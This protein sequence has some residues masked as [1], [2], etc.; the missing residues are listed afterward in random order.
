[1]RAGPNALANHIR[2][3][4]IPRSCGPPPFVKGALG[5]LFCVLRVGWVEFRRSPSTL[6]VVL[7]EITEFTLRRRMGSR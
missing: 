6:A 3:N 1:M 4:Q 7:M 2:R 5:D